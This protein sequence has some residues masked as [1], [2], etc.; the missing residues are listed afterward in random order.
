[1]MTLENRELFKASKKERLTCLSTVDEMVRLSMI[2]RSQGCLALEEEAE[3][4]ENKFLSFGLMLAVGGVGPE[5]I[6]DILEKYII[7]SGKTG[8][9]LLRQAIMLEGILSITAGLNPRIIKDKLTIM[10]GEDVYLNPDS[11]DEDEPDEDRFT[12]EDIAI[13]NAF[14]IQ[15]VLR[16]AEHRE[17]ALALKGSSEEVTNTIF[18]NL[19]KNAVEM[20]K[21]DMQVM[22]VVRTSDAE[23]AR[24][25]ILD[26]IRRLAECG[27]I[28]ISK[29]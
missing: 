2:A 10:L 19:S 25:K 29:Q 18:L 9:E 7:A 12:F 21:D 1:M 28:F 20:I 17:I 16:E 22:G 27:E 15:R 6:Q 23:E 5:L 26:I 24:Q 4:E 13:L 8:V 11:A 3:K 14:D